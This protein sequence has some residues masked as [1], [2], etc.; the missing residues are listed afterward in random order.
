MPRRPV[1]AV[2]DLHRIA[3][4]ES[5]CGTAP[6][7]RL[8]PRARHCIP[9]ATLLRLS[10]SSAT[11]WVRCFRRGDREIVP[12]SQVRGARLRVSTPPRST[13]GTQ[14][15]PGPRRR[16]AIDLLSEPLALKSVTAGTSTES[17]TRQPLPEWRHLADSFHPRLWYRGAG[18]SRHASSAMPTENHVLH[19]L[20]RESVPDC[21][22]SPDVTHPA[23]SVRPSWQRLSG[24][25]QISYGARQVRR[26]LGPS[27]LCRECQRSELGRF[28]S[29][30]RPG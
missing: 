4:M 28:E 13:K 6:L 7:P 24:S 19:P 8:L 17:Q 11:S 18:S 26:P 16:R 27:P 22:P 12:A 25:R 30:V 23:P 1:S 20:G 5:P 9:S 2:C 21:L 10:S 29:A 14:A 3:V 15:P